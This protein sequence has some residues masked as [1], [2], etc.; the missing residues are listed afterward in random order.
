MSEEAPKKGYSR[1]R[2]LIYGGPFDLGA[3]LL[4][5]L[6]G[7]RIDGRQNIPSEGPY[8]VWL[9][10]PNLIGM[11]LSGMV[12]IKVLKKEMLKNSTNNISYMQEELFRYKFFKKA[13]ANPDESATTTAN[14]RPLVPH[15]AG[16]LALGLLDGY[17]VLMNKGIVIINPEGDAPYDGRPLPI[18]RALPW[19]ALR[20]AA[21]ILPIL[22]SV[23]A[24]DVWP[25]W[26]LYPNR[27]G[28][29]GIPVGKPF[30]LCEEPLPV[31]GAEDMARA[32]ARLR[33]EFQ[34]RYGPNGVSGWAGPILR[35]GVPVAGPVT[36]KPPSKPLA[37]VPPL[38]PAVKPMTR[39]VA[40]LL[41]ECPV[42]HTDEALVQARGRGWPKTVGC[43]ACATR[44]EL[45]RVI[46]HDFRLRVVAGPPELMGLDMALSTWYDEMMASFR[47]RPIRVSGPGLLP[48]EEMYLEKSDVSLLPYRPN[49]LF[50]AWTERE[51]PKK[52]GRSH[53]YASWASIGTGQLLLTD[54]RLL[55]RAPDRELDFWWSSVTAISAYMSNLLAIRYGGAMYRFD[56]GNALLLKWL[57]YAAYAAKR[58]AQVDGHELSVSY[59]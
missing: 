46:G 51:P 39:G 38:A 31:V 26:Q 44:W 20:T 5:L 27:K 50:E 3:L 13:L 30:R 22:T 59:E 41:F 48:D 17:R 43:Q 35:N 19:L 10:E 57:K 1:L 18:G 7:F 25:R 56:L 14:F 28:R 58:V 33:Q 54:Q 47:P 45:G 2:A 49:P 16:Q 24:Y 12:S 11:V 6:Y 52:T 53:E 32:D 55:W 40:Q 9:T 4:K 37:A 21:P 15:A 42:C 36:H 8:I 29:I 23:G 34:R